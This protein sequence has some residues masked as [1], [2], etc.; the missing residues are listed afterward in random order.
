MREALKRSA[1]LKS[2]V[3]LLLLPTPVGAPIVGFIIIDACDIPWEGSFQCPVPAPL[4]DYFLTFT[5]LPFLWTG[6]FIGILWLILSLAVLFFCLWFA[7]R[8][9]WDATMERP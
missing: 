7:L 2:L 9:I 8:A 3:L 5:M 6:P 1:A 4:L